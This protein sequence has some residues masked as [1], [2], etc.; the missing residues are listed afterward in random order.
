MLCKVNGIFKIQVMLSNKQIQELFDAI[1]QLHLKITLKILH[2]RIQ[3][4][5]GRK[6]TDLSH[7]ITNHLT[8]H[9]HHLASKYEET[10]SKAT[11]EKTTFS[12][13]NRSGA[14]ALD[15]YQ[16][17]DT[18]DIINPLTNYLKNK[19]YTDSSH[20]GIADTLISSTWYHF[21]A[22]IREARQGK[23]K[24]CGNA[25]GYC[26]LRNERSGALFTGRRVPKLL[27]R[28]KS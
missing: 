19:K 17:P 22:A 8:E 11:W 16:N 4:H 13:N 18:T 10:T 26:Q 14:T 3:K 25:R 15:D 2:I 9:V 27:F 5:N 28:Y 20:S 21:H 6:N 12:I 1:F 23:K 7:Y 24:D